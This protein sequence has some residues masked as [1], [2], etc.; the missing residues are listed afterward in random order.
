MI[1]Q[2]KHMEN[3]LII[4]GCHFFIKSWQNS[5]FLRICIFLQKIRGGKTDFCQMITMSNH[6][7]HHM[8]VK[9]SSNFQQMI[10][11]SVIFAKQLQH[12]TSIFLKQSQY[13]T[14]MKLSGDFFM[15]AK[16]NDNLCQAIVIFV[17]RWQ[18]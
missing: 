5:T 13:Q 14:T 15:F 9:W 8:I 17:K 2:R 12:Q 4:Q 7:F 16:L 3:T 18:R 1:I 11:K 10:L 6:N